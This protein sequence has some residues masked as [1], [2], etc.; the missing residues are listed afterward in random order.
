M[1]WHGHHLPEVP[2]A[3]CINWRWALRE[4]ILE[5]PVLRVA[6]GQPVEEA[7]LRYHKAVVVMPL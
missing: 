5:T 4:E 6:W 3:R 7:A 1:E 2:Y